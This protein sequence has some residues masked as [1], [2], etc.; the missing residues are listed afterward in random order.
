MNCMISSKILVLMLIFIV[1]L[2]FPPTEASISQETIIRQEEPR[3][4][5]PWATTANFSNSMTVRPVF[6]PDNL[7]G[8]LVDLFNS[9]KTSIDVQ[10]QYVK[11]FT[12]DDP[13]D[14]YLDNNF[15]VTALIAAAGR[16]VHVRENINGLSRRHLSCVT[17]PMFIGLTCLL[18]GNLL[19]SF[20]WQSRLPSPACC[21]TRPLRN[22][23]YRSP[24]TPI[25][26]FL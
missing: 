26:R 3:A 13:S 15:L 2:N 24:K 7:Y 18:G 14:W 5:T 1:P 10:E 19:W 21:R 8:E 17:R 6:T 11:M 20:D 23:T 9:A 12:Y 16:G 4:Y 25:E 22:V